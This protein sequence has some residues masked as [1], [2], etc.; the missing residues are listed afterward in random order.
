VTSAETAEDFKFIFEAAS[1][2]FTAFTGQE[3]RPSVLE[4]DGAHAITNAC[5]A[6]FPNTTRIMCWFHVSQNVDK[7][8]STIRSKKIQDAIREDIHQLQLA[9]SESEFIK[10]SGLWLKKWEGNQEA[11]SFVSYF[12]EEYINNNSGWFE[13]LAL[14]YPSTNNCLEA[15][16]NVVKK[17][18]TM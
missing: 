9:K 1:D 6:V 7:K 11:N 16:N 15:T 5:D 18:W 14:G 17:E 3:Y 10:A 13:G 4:A 2:A 8:L 12:R